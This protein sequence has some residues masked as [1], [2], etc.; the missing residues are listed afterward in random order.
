MKILAVSQNWQ[1]AN[2]YSFVRAFR[3]AG[4]SVL[5]VS[6]QD[7]VPTGLRSRALRL[8]RRLALPL[9]VEDYQSALIDAAMRYKPDLFFVYKGTYVKAETIA[10][11]KKLGAVAVNVYPDIGLSSQSSYLVSAMAQYD[12]VF[13]TK[14]FRVRYLEEALGVPKVLFMPHAY[15]PEVHSPVHLEPDEWDRYASDVA[16]IGTWSPKKGALVEYLRSSL[17]DINLKVWG[18]QWERASPILAGTCQGGSLLGLEYAKGI[19]AAKIVLA[20][21]VESPADSTQG[22][23]TT[24]RTFEIPAIGS[25]MLHERTEEASGFFEEGRECGMFADREELVAK[26]R[27]YL[28]NEH[29]REAIAQ[30]GALRARQS[31]YDY[32]ARIGT[33]LEVV[34]EL[35]GVRQ[36][37]PER[38]R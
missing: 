8:A 23:L 5:V 12:V 26:I 18:N 32:G 34:R 36:T 27:Y 28:D 30:A 37:L 14:S 21:L 19:R 16:F 6:D 3:R 33:V 25:F 24:A 35:R 9:L 20:A 1:G 13:T 17:P 15:D 2:D 31:G 22:D 38:A 7:H 10:T 11:I 4:H 29:E